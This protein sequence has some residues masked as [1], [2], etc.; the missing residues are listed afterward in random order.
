MLRMFPPS[1]VRERGVIPELVGSTIAPGRTATG[2]MPVIAADGGGLWRIELGELLLTSRALTHQ[3]RAMMSAFDL[4]ATPLIVPFRDT[5]HAPWAVSGG[6]DLTEYPDVLHSDDATFDDDSGYFQPAI[7]AQLVNSAAL[8][9]TELTIRFQQGGPLLGGEFFSIDH[10]DLR[11]R[12][13]HIIKCVE[14]SDGD[15]VCTIRP[16]LREATNSGTYCEF[17]MP[18]CV[19]RL[20]GGARMDMRHYN[21]PSPVFIEA[22]PPLE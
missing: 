20:L 3:Y 6:S 13:Y 4:G 8:R 12:L 1:L 10:E 2:V 14:E 16:P 18:R 11:W 5:R 22:F 7:V 15:W 21:T 9:A 17:D 19:M